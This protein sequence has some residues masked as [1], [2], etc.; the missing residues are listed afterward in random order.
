MTEQSKPLP[1]NPLRCY[2]IARALSLHELAESAGMT[3]AMLA[4]VE[5]GRRLLSRQQQI[6]LAHTLRID[7]AELADYITGARCADLGT[8]R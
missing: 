7:P 2:R 4:A 6:D 5:E 1:E 3:R 8:Q